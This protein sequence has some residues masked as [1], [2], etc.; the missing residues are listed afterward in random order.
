MSPRFKTVR[1]NNSNNDE[2]M[3]EDAVMFNG[4]L[5]TASIIIYIQKLHEDIL[6]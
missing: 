5:C 3:P 4:V 1:D 6:G 2:I